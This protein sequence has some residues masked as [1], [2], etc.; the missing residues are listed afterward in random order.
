[1]DLGVTTLRVFPSGSTEAA[2]IAVPFGPSQTDEFTF[3]LRA[4]P[5][6]GT[7]QI[8]VGNGPTLQ[9]VP[10]Q[11]PD[12]LRSV[13]DFLEVVDKSDTYPTSPNETYATL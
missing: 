12:I 11:V 9:G 3:L 7:T 10:G 1:M 6:G 2:A 13:A 8:L 4:Q 5:P